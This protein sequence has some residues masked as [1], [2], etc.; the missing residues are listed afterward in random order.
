MAKLRSAGFAHPVKSYN[1]VDIEAFHP[2]IIANEAQ[3]IRRNMQAPTLSVL[4][5]KKKRHNLWI[6]AM[7]FHAP[8]IIN[9]S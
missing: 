2:T 7:S 8:V 4:V 6:G 3:T 5:M 1:S 9:N